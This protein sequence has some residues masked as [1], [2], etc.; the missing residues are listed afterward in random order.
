MRR[1]PESPSRCSLSSSWS[2]WALAGYWPGGRVSRDCASRG[3]PRAC[4]TWGNH[5]GCPYNP[6]APVPFV[7][8]T[9]GFSP[10]FLQPF[11]TAAVVLIKFVT[12]GVLL[13]IVLVV[14]LGRIKSR[15]H[16]DL[17]N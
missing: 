11:C 12:Q 7:P 6:Q 1:M 9:L 10:E 13:V 4:P 14:V 5:K 15:G 3:R 17:G 8:Q 16:G 2:C